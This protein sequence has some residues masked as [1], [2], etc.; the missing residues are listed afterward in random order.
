VHSISVPTICIYFPEYIN[1][2]LSL[3]GASSSLW[4]RERVREAEKKK[5]RERVFISGGKSIRNIKAYIM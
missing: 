2:L 3:L 5:Y 4:R 1:T